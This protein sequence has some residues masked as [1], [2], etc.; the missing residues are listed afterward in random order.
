MMTAGKKEKIKIVV[1]GSVALDSVKT[2]FGERREML[3]GS[4]SYACPAASFFA[5]TGMVGVVGD[6]FSTDHLRFYRRMGINLEGLQK[7]R[8]KTFRWSGE[9]EKDLVNRRTLSTELNVF[10]AFKP[11]LPESYRNAGYLL[12]GNISPSLQ[13]H[14]LEQMRKPALVLADTM[15]LW[16]RT[17][18]RN[19]Q[20][21][22]KNAT[23]LA[24]ND[25]E[26]REL[27]GKHD[28]RQSAAAILKMGP[29][30]VVIKKGEHGS[31]LFFKNRI[32][33]IPAYPVMKVVD[34]T[35]A[36]D[37]F[38]GGFIGRLAQ[39]GRVNEGRIIEAMLTGSVVA[40]FVVES[41]GV[42]AMKKLTRE[43]IASRLSEFEK[44]IRIF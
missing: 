27:T 34:P 25:S 39:A 26:A 14:V 28:L 15:D 1:V 10:A 3:G 12:L 18:R 20:K 8:G 21:V 23:M 38:A 32:S 4:V 11:E 29:K 9:Y 6:D 36:G 19:L 44:I 13:L 41:F 33:I 7:S 40:S 37:S 2:K 35:G 30:Y 31:M 17:E 16:I 5:T 43:K 42:D 24:L 22:L